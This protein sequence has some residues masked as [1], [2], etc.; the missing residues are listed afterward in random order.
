MQ[1]VF[2]SLQDLGEAERDERLAK[3]NSQVITPLSAEEVFMFDV[4]LCDNAIDRVGDKL[5]INFLNAL[6]EKSKSLIGLKDHAWSSDNQLCRLYD[7]EVV[8]DESRK[9]ENDEPYAY[10]LGHAYTLRAFDDLVKRIES[11]LLKECSISFKS[12]GDKCSI[13]GAETSKNEEGLAVCSIGHVATG[14]YDGQVCFNI[15]DNCEDVFEWS[16]VAVPCQRNA[17]IKNK[18]GS[19]MRKSIFFL[20]KA[21]A[22]A[23]YKSM[24]EEV[25]KQIDD[26][27]AGGDEEISEDEVKALLEENEQLK[28]RVKELEEELKA[29]AEAEMSRNVSAVVE[30]AVDALEPFN[31]QVKEDIISKIDLGAVTIGEDGVVSGLDDQIDIL[32]KKYDGLLKGCHGKEF[33]E[34]TPTTSIEEKSADETLKPEEKAEE[35]EGA[36]PNGAVVAKKFQPTLHASAGG[37]NVVKKSFHDACKSL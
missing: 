22:S 4:V 9:T 34:E 21:K 5:T 10:V 17:A 36:A 27:V 24:P 20:N 14:E 25:Q 26:A 8:V 15:V 2:K 7:T 19:L 30:K 13:C 35:K 23:S 37:G 33:T 16:L 31:A 3:I 6:A 29:K 28:A 11:G 1:V 18:G 12:T 32:T